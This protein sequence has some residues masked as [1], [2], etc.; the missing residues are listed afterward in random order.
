MPELVEFARAHPEATVIGVNVN[1]DQDAATAFVARQGITFPNVYDPNGELFNRFASRGLPTTV[2]LNADLE[3][4]D[5]VV[6][7]TDM[8]GFEAGLQ[9]AE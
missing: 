9:T 4:T 8:S 6:G 5:T 2:F 7:A 3:V 1:D